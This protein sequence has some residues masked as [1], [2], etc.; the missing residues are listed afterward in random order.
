MTPTEN[1]RMMMIMTMITGYWISQLVYG[2]AK[3]SLADHLASGPATAADIAKMAGLNPSATPRRLSPRL[4]LVVTM[5][6]SLFAATMRMI[7]SALSSFGVRFGFAFLE[8]LGL[9]LISG[10]P[11]ATPLTTLTSK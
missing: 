2:A 4:R 11:S 6:S 3:Y 1:D 5:L 9:R 10:S 7:V 8:V